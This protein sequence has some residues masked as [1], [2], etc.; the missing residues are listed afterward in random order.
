M[1]RAYEWGYGRAIRDSAA[2]D[3]MAGVLETEIPMPGLPDSRSQLAVPIVVGSAL[4][5]VLYVEDVL[6]RRFGFDD[7]DAL[8]AVAALLGPTMRSMQELADAA[9]EA[10]PPRDGAAAVARRRGDGAPLRGGRQRVPRRRLPDQGRGGRDLLEAAARLQSERTHR[11]HQSRAAPRPVASA[12]PISPT[13][14]KR[15]SSCCRAGWPSARRTSRSRRP[16]AA[17]SAFA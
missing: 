9:Q 8:V 5:A 10:A 15:A 6:D 12:C 17:A 1:H 2:A 3:G 16:D 11:V 14:S 13:T 4:S 7:E